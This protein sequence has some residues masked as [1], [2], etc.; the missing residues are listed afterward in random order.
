MKVLL[1]LVSIAALFGAVA[2]VPIYGGVLFAFILFGLFLLA[3]VGAIGEQE[4]RT[5]RQH[6][7]VADPRG[8][9]HGP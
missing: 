2:F 8:W 5:V 6:D 9:R 4:D 1:T 3:L 7:W